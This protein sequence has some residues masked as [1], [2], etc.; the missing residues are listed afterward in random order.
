MRRRVAGVGEGAIGRV[1]SRGRGRRGTNTD[2]RRTAAA[3]DSSAD[4]RTAAVRLVLF[5]AVAVLVARATGLACTAVTVRS[6]RPRLLVDVV[7]V[8]VAAAIRHAVVVG[9]AV[10]AAAAASVLVL[11]VESTG[12]CH[13]TVRRGSRG[14]L[15][16][17]EDRADTVGDGGKDPEEEG[18]LEAGEDGAG[19]AGLA[20]F[21]TGETAFWCVATRSVGVCVTENDHGENKGMLRNLPCGA[22]KMVDRTKAATRAAPIPTRT[23]AQMGTWWSFVSKSS[24]LLPVLNV[25]SAP[26]LLLAL[27]PMLSVLP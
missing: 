14:L 6:R 18:K 9:P 20:I 27:L 21:G 16:T 24:L 4:G 5:V 12:G 23:Q 26:L 3:G 10:K 2:G 1:R 8:I 7:V 11:G 17:T 15:A 22:L 13:F 19:V 25:V